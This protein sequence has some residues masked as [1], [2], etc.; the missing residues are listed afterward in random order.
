MSSL[1]EK[2]Y[3]SNGRKDTY[4]DAR[5]GTYQVAEKERISEA[6]R[7]NLRADSLGLNSST[8][9]PLRV[10]HTKRT[11]QKSKTNGQCAL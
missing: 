9:G 11:P 10:K 7:A 5:K 4:L 3:I 6:D 8:A 1:S 2:G